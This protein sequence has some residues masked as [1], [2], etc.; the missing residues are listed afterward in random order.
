MMYTAGELR[1]NCFPQLLHKYF[2]EDFEYDVANNDT[3]D[4][5]I[6]RYRILKMNKISEVKNMEYGP[7]TPET[8]FVVVSVRRD[9]LRLRY[10]V[11]ALA[12][13]SGVDELL[14]IFSHSHFDRNIN[15]LIRQI[16]FCMVLQIFYP[17]SVQ[18][19]PNVFPGIEEST[20]DALQAERK[21]HWWWTARFVFE[22]LDAKIYP[23]HDS[24]TDIV[25]FVDESSYILPDFTYMLSIS[26]YSMIYFPNAVLL[27][28]GRPPAA[29]L[30]Y[31]V[32]TVETWHSPHANGMAFY[33]S[34]WDKI[35]ASS[36]HYCEY[37]DTSWSG[38]LVQ[39][40]RR[41]PCGR[42]QA[43]AVRVP[44]VLD[45]GVTPDYELPDLC[46][47][48]PR[49]L[50]YPKK[51]QAVVLYS[52]DG[53]LVTEPAEPPPRGNGGWSD[54]RDVNLCYAILNG[55]ENE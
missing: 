36:R 55:T 37:D 12:Q 46:L 39:V 3:L 2:S 1:E 14:L 18:L 27:T 50:L 21:H 5:N 34:T 23:S 7:L 30:Q 49:D 9:L 6:L 40:F 29:D 15:N 41:L 51:V 42:A 44:R 22:H 4:L 45:T 20:R 53:K 31:H 52:H 11:A 33:R 47:T 25:I 17:Y 16:D 38:S 8:P 48:T 32:V 28:F 19:H 24:H 13:L 26:K 54:L 35:R 10:L 43:L